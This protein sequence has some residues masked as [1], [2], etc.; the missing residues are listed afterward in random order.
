MSCQ[1]FHRRNIT[2]LLT[3]RQ[4]YSEIPHICHKTLSLSSLLSNFLPCQVTPYMLPNDVSRHPS[5][6]YRVPRNV[7]MECKGA[8][9]LSH[10][11]KQACTDVTLKQLNE[12]VVVP[13][14]HVTRSHYHRL[15]IMGPHLLSMSHA[16]LTTHPPQTNLLAHLNY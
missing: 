13:I 7:Q 3:K 1:R 11:Q 10:T 5:L 15:W 16:S 14:N 2:S 6:S 8:F 4:I 12:K 9:Q